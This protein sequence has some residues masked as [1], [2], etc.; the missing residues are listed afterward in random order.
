[1]T[2]SNDIAQ[3]VNSTDLPRWTVDAI[4]GHITN[5]SDDYSHISKESIE[6]DFIILELDEASREAGMHPF[7]PDD[8]DEPLD[9]AEESWKDDIED[10]LY[11][12]LGRNE[13]EYLVFRP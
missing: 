7:D 6:R 2:T 12:C 4:I 9:G 13:D 5:A 3:I 10:N 11:Y 1:M 8:Y